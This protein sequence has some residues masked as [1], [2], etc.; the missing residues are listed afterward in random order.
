M[1]SIIIHA[2]LFAVSALGQPDAAGPA[3]EDLTPKA[4]ACVAALASVSTH[5]RRDNV[6]PGRLPLSV[7]FEKPAGPLA[8]L[9]RETGEILVS[10]GKRLFGAPKPEGKQNGYSYDHA[11][12]WR[13]LKPSLFRRIAVPDGRVVDY[14]RVGEAKPAREFVRLPNEQEMMLEADKELVQRELNA[15]LTLVEEYLAKFE[16]TCD[17]ALHPETSSQARGLVAMFTEMFA[18]KPLEGGRRQSPLEAK[19]DVEG[20]MASDF[21]QNAKEARRKLEAL[22]AWN[23][24]LDGLKAEREKKENQVATKPLQLNADALKE[25]VSE[26][27]KDFNQGS[28]VDKLQDEQ[29]AQL[30]EACSGFWKV[31]APPPA[32]PKERTFSDEVEKNLPAASKPFY[33]ALKGE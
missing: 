31:P 4:A 14:H 28:N 5:V 27:V 1:N 33:K 23:A 10:D 7:E 9:T 24:K 13:T 21:A 30:S 2:W 25:L 22:S 29:R 32:P 3:P 11:E 16:K 15:N 20:G 26:Q 12:K 18:F 19:I 6:V 8:I 17:E